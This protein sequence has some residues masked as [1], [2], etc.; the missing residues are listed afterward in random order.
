[1]SK[2]RKMTRLNIAIA[3]SLSLLLTACGGLTD[4]GERIAAACKA[5]AL[6]A[7]IDCNCYAEELQDVLSADEL[8]MMVDMTENP[9]SAIGRVREPGF[10]E[11]MT[12]IGNLGRQAVSSCMK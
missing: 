8:S 7:Q 1:M 5:N 11:Q 12:R 4:D 6:D 9:L 10:M 3:V 2:K